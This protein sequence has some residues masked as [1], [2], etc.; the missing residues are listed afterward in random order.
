MNDSLQPIISDLQMH[1]KSH[2]VGK[3]DTTYS[4]SCSARTQDH[5]HNFLSSL[6][7][8]EVLLSFHL[9]EF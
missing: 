6:T 9:V 5:S 2:V 7:S 4:R 3:R 8:D 1:D